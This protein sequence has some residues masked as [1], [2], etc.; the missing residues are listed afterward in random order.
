MGR[1]PI[2]QKSQP[3]YK[4]AGDQECEESGELHLAEV[5]QWPPQRSRSG[6]ANPYI[7]VRCARCGSH[8]LVYADNDPVA[9][10]IEVK[11]PEAIGQSSKK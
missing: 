6:E 7:S 11:V 1:R 9:S 8:L 2:V 4:Y 10:G 5:K 3:A